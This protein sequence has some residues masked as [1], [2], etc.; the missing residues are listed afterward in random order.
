MARVGNH[1]NGMNGIAALLAL[2]AI[3]RMGEAKRR[4]QAEADGPCRCGSERPAKECCLRGGRWFKVPAPIDLT[5]ADHQTGSHPKCYL[6]DLHSCSDTISG[7]HIISEAVLRAVATEKVS[8]SGFPWLKGEEK[9]LSFSNLTSN[10]L[11]TRHN[12]LLSPLDAAAG[13][14]FNALKLS[15]LGRSSPS[16]RY[17]FSGHDIE[18]WLLKTLANMVASKNIAR[19]G[20]RITSVFHPRADVATLL[21]NVNSW[22]RAAGMYFIGKKE[23]I[24]FR[25]D[26]FWLEPLT[27]REPAEVVGMK[28]SMQGLEFCFL[29]VPPDAGT[30]V[31]SG[32]FRPKSASFVHQDVR[33]C[34]EFS[35]DDGLPH[36]DIELKFKST[37]GER[38]ASGEPLP[39]KIVRRM[40]G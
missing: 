10:C 2:C 31:V 37:F 32:N 38:L 23:E 5:G 7:E 11:C 19:D 39:A 17:L 14:F 21:T 20:D 12:S 34:I 4:R 18:R 8:V 26:H 16:R 36:A 25:D 28:A 22:P 15:D 33:N 35:W 3:C 6:R 9:L 13:A 27:I 30:A 40:D 29:I 1:E 24:I